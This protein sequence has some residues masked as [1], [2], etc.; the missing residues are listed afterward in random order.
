MQLSEILKTTRKRALMTQDDFAAKMCVTTSTINR[1][2]HGKVRPNITAM[3]RLKAFCAE[4]KFSFEE[5][6]TAW[7]KEDK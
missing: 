4:Q 5:I 1:W 2:E 7:L 3:K 6:E